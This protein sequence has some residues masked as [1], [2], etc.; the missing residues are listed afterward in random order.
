[1]PFSDIANKVS[2]TVKETFRIST[3]ESF[4]AFLSM[5]TGI[6]LGYTHQ[7]LRQIMQVLLAVYS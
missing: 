2:K 1:M 5:K 3:V 6:I 4:A 7:T